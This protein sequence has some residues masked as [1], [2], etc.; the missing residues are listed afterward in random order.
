M[1]QLKNSIQQVLQLGHVNIALRFTVLDQLVLRH[2]A[3]HHCVLSGLGDLHANVRGLVSLIVVS[4]L[5]DK[6]LRLG[7][8]LLTVPIT[9]V[10]IL[11][12]IIQAGGVLVARRWSAFLRFAEHLLFVE[13]ADVLVRVDNHRRRLGV[14][15][16]FLNSL[17]GPL[18]SFFCLLLCHQFLHLFHFLSFFVGG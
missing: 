1:Q 5:G 12:R 7:R 13:N 4:H 10:L 3:S 18:L 15:F 11:T 16:N 2:E 8:L 9:V 6:N 17:F 14:N